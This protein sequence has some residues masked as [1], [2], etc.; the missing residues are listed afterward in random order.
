MFGWLLCDKPAGS[1]QSYVVSSMLVCPIR[2]ALQTCTAMFCAQ[3][4]LDA[5]G[6]GVRSVVFRLPQY[7]WGHGGSLFILQQLDAARK[8]HKAYYILPGRHGSS[9]EDS[10]LMLVSLGALLMRA[11]VAVNLSC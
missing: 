10:K 1:K 9:S 4:A 7:V 5:A 8:L 3:A 11:A 6:H 2:S